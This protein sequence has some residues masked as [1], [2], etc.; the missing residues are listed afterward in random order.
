MYS[1]GGGMTLDFFFISYFIISISC[2]SPFHIFIHMI[3]VDSLTKNAVVIMGFCTTVYSPDDEI[4]GP[5]VVSKNELQVM[6]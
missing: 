2:D 6:T 1:G 3:H 5:T 4:A